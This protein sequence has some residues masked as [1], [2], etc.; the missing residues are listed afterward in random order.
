MTDDSGRG[1]EVR[2]YH[3][4]HW[5]EGDR[6][7][8]LPWLGVFLLIFGG[9]LLLEQIVPEFQPA[10]ATFLLA[11]GLAFLVSWILRRGTGALYAGAIVTALALPDVLQGTGVLPDAPGWGTLFLGAAFLFIALVRALG[12]GGWGW[13]TWLGGILFV[14]GATQVVDPSL[15]RIAWPLLVVLVGVAIIAGGLR[16]TTGPR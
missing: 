8:G 7:P 6:R 1:G 3:W 4:G 11:V 9:L 12:R 14:V 16:R 15:G 2:A 10:G 13:Q 5:E